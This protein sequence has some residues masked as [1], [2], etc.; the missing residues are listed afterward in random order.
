VERCQNTTQYHHLYHF[1]IFA[2]LLPTSWQYLLEQQTPGNL[3]NTKL[4]A[5]RL[6]CWICQQSYE[7]WTI[8][9]SSIHE[10]TTTPST[11][12][13]ILNQKILHLYSLQHEL[14]ATDRDI[15]AIP[16][17]ERFNLTEKQKLLWITHTTKTVS[18]CLLDHQQKIQSGQKDIQSYFNP[19]VPTP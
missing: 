4:W 18:T 17:E 13:Q 11:T 8:R 15:F 10:H 7:L 5:T 1:I 9:N 16:L 12:H 14:L 3:T 19:K 6:S 2:G